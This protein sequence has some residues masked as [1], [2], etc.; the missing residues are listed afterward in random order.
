MNKKSVFLIEILI[1]ICIMLLLAGGW[2]LLFS[3]EISQEK[4]LKIEMGMSQEDV[5]EFI[6]SGVEVFPDWN[7]EPNES[8]FEYQLN[9]GNFGCVYYKW[10][11]SEGIYYVRKLTI[12]DISYQED[13]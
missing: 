1:F 5:A 9:D 7:L 6:G 2:N 13:K 10:K 8:I 12:S 4:F 3:S 11:E